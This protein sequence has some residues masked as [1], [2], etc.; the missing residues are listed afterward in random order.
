MFTF[1]IEK[2][3]DTIKQLDIYRTIHSKL[4]EY[5]FLQEHV[6]YKPR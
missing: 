3:I 4:A 2:L 5:T 6:G 1:D